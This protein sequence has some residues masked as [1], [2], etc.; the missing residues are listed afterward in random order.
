MHTHIHIYTHIHAY[1]HAYIY[2]HIHMHTHTYTCIH[3]SMYTCIHTYAHMH[4]CIELLVY[5][6][7]LGCGVYTY[8][9]QPCVSLK[10]KKSVV[11]YVRGGWEDQGVFHTSYTYTH[12]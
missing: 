12:T 5:T 1:T 7:Y 3:T 10:F 4:T 6:A 2:T 11:W 9:F 8:T